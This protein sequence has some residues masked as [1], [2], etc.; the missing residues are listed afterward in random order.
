MRRK[1]FQQAVKYVN[2]NE[3]RI[4]ERAIEQ[5]SRELPETVDWSD[6][7]RKETRAEMLSSASVFFFVWT[8]YERQIRQAMIDALDGGIE[9]H[10]AVYS[11]R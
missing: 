1:L 8:W 4:L 5:S 9:V 10:D 11:K 2:D 7:E 3:P 6:V